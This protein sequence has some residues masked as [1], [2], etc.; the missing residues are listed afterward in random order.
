[1]GH[2][3]AKLGEACSCAEVNGVSST[4]S[5]DEG[6]QHFTD[7]P[8]AKGCAG[9]GGGGGGGGSGAFDTWQTAR[10]EAGCELWHFVTLRLDRSV[11][12]LAD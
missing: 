10:A 6:C 3:S 2:R 9:A 8:A 5:A 11:L 1:M 4:A 7:L 12:A